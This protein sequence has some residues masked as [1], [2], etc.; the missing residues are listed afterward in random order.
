MILNIN[1]ESRG[2]ER[3]SLTLVGSVLVFLIVFSFSL[4]SPNA[5]DLVFNVPFSTVHY[6]W[7]S[8]V[9]CLNTLETLGQVI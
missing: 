6:G 7:A 3:Q 2:K 8:L 9:D 1:L 5:E 4:F